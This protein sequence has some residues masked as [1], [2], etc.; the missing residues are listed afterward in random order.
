MVLV[1]SWRLSI[2]TGNFGSG[3]TE[4]ALNYALK[5]HAD[6]NQVSIADLDI[7][8]PYFRTRM[9]RECLES[10][11]ITVV[12]PW[13]KLAGADVPA[14]PAAIYGVLQ[15]NAGYGV[16]DVGGDDI[17]ATVL[18]RF[19]NNLPAGAF[20]LFLVVNVCR[21]FTR[22]VEGITT[23]L[24]S[25]EKTSR[26]RVNALV[27]NTNLGPETD[28]PVIL[29]GHRVVQEAARQLGLPVAFACARRDLAASLGDLNIPVLPL[30][31]FMKPPWYDGGEPESPDPHLRIPPGLK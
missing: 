26:L 24:R 11:G 6:G 7:I 31:L 18:G 5:I 3:K 20:N 17:G 30:D 10:M 27:S 4:V 19:K 1:N 12:S 8:N 21:P 29:E 25:I 28:V 22:D 14:L 16:I 2:F 23:V 13:G 15:G 9:V